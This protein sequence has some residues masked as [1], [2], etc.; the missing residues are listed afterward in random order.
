MKTLIEKIKQ[1]PEENYPISIGL[2]EEMKK[3][4]FNTEN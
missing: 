4:T 3:L 1:K 2:I